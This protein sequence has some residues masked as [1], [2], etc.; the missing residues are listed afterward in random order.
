MAMVI[1]CGRTLVLI[2]VTVTVFQ[3]RITILPDVASPQVASTTIPT[4]VLPLQATRVAP[5]V[6]ISSS[7]AT[8]IPVKEMLYE[9]DFEDGQTS[10]LATISGRWEVMDDGTGNLA[11]TTNGQRSQ[12]VIE[13]G[14]TWEDYTITFRYRLDGVSSASN[15]LVWTRRN[16]DANYYELVI[17]T[18]FNNFGKYVNG[19]L[20]NLDDGGHFNSFLSSNRWHNVTIELNASNLK[21]EVDDIP[22]GASDESNRSGTAGFGTYSFY[23]RVWIDDIVVW[24]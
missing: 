6:G 10:S 20:T 13:G 2:A 24:K 16:N 12:I 5:T 1:F 14:A 4:T 21:W 8:S 18:D 22:L 17:G 9:E 7:A 11:L 15:F 19:K 3:L 23:G